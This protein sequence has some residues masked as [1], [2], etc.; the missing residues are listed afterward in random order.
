MNQE[1]NP[2]EIALKIESKRKDVDDQIKQIEAQLLSYKKYDFD[3]GL[4]DDEGYPL[5]KIA[6]RAKNWKD[7]LALGVSSGLIPEELKGTL[8]GGL[9]LLARL[10]GNPDTI[11]APLSFNNRVM[12][13]GPFPIGT[14]PQIR[15]NP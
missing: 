6:V 11:D 10:S 9:G 8:E 2:R 5:G 13:L 3:Q 14:A 15:L 1:E 12:S 4:L 7:M